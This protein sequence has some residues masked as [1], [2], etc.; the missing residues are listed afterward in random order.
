LSQIG[1]LTIFRLKKKR[2]TWKS[3]ILMTIFLEEISP[4]TFDGSSVGVDVGVGI[5]DGSNGSHI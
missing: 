2:A 1:D 5:D 3:V 4:A